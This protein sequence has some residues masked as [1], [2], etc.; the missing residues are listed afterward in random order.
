MSC[1]LSLITIPSLWAQVPTEKELSACAKKGYEVVAAMEKRDTTTLKQM[2]KGKAGLDYLIARLPKL[3]LYQF[4][5]TSSIYYHPDSNA[6]IVN[7]ILGDWIPTDDD[8][9]LYD[10]A[11]VVE[12]TVTYNKAN[13]MASI[14]HIRILTPDSDLKT[15]WQSLLLSYNE[16]RYLR[17]KFAELYGLVAPPPPPPQTKDWLS[18]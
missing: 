9:G 3:D 11:A 8:W 15:W 2:L 1:L 5:A 4:H 17:D 10:Y 12:M 13:G 14:R 16:K 6:F 7:V 18:H